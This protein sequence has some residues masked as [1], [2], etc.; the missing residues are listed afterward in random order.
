MK[1][2]NE[3]ESRITRFQ[4]LHEQNPGARFFA[5]L[6]DL[7]RQG[8]RHEEALRL[9]SAGMASHEGYLA[10]LVIQGRTLQ[11][12]GRQVDA[13]DVWRQVRNIDPDNILALEFLVDWSLGRREWERAV[14]LLERLC[15]V[16]GEDSRWHDTLATARAELKAHLEV[17]RRDEVLTPQETDPAPKPD[18]ES[19]G[20]S[21]RK[22][23]RKSDRKTVRKPAGAADDA[24]DS[25]S[26]DTM[27]LV[28]IYLA[29]GYRDRAL[30]VLRRML[31]GAGSHSGEIL[32]RIRVLE[33]VDDDDDGGA[34]SMVPALEISTD[35]GRGEPETRATRPMTTQDRLVREEERARRREVERKQFEE[36]LARIRVDNGERD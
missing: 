12:V 3:L 25:T 27:T 35:P 13:H 11:E 17:G 31:P 24:D 36:W 5:P 29:Q 34:R 33:A 6:A 7:L 14:P 16:V 32:E 2:L 28:D 23:V 15:S 26:F 10:G 21:A 8:G 4:E 19:A 30:S 1:S 9:L 22:S 20:K 18:A